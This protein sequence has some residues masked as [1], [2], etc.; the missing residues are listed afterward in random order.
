MLHLR[1]VQP[2]GVSVSF[3]PNSYMVTEGNER[4]LRVVLSGDYDIPVEVLLSTTGISATGTHIC[5]SLVLYNYRTI[6]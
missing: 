3:M 2:L 1:Q 5:I 4:E 6:S